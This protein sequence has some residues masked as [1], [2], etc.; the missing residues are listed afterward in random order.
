[1][2]L[3]VLDGLWCP[4]YVL[5]TSNRILEIPQQVSAPPAGHEESHDSL[6]VIAESFLSED[7]WPSLEEV[8][9]QTNF[10]NLYDSMDINGN[11]QHRLTSENVE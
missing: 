9:G 3:L 2:D 4:Y 10:E 7:Y 11:D 8:M 1:M 5:S 6:Q